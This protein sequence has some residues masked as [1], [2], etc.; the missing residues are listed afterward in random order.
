M[1]TGLTS[2]AR[3]IKN[4]FRPPDT[5]LM[6]NIVEKEAELLKIAGLSDTE[7]LHYLEVSATRLVDQASIYQ[8]KLDE[9]K[10]LE[11]LRW[12][13]SSPFT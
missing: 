10:H 5:S 12:L 4:V 13:S 1:F 9:A 7:K 11:L 2:I 3:T 8:K 6:E